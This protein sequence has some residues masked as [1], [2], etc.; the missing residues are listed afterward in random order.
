MSGFS[1]TNAIAT[2]KPTHSF[3]ISSDVWA[4]CR[5]QKRDMPGGAG[6]RGTKS[7]LRPSDTISGV[8]QTTISATDS[9]ATAL[10]LQEQPRRALD[11][12]LARQIEVLERR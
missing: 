6:S 4:A 1:R 8:S 3:S 5:N 7:R 2:A 9:S 10:I 12:R 11:L